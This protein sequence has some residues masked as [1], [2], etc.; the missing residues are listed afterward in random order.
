MP[1]SD[2]LTVLR[3]HVLAAEGEQASPGQ[4]A[5]DIER[6]LERAGYT[7]ISNEAAALLTVIVSR[8]GVSEFGLDQLL[9]D[10][11]LAKLVQYDPQV[12]STNSDIS[13]GADYLQ[14]STALMAVLER[15][16]DHVSSVTVKMQ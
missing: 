5:V 13:A 3:N 11:G 8:R 4:K 16:R 9:L 1:H 15:G 10:L 7:I 6:A 12:H 2:P 14:Y